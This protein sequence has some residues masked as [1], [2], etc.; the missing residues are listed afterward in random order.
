MGATRQFRIKIMI[1]LSAYKITWVEIK[2]TT[3]I[4]TKADNAKIGGCRDLDDKAKI[5][6]HFPTREAALSFLKS[7]DKKL[8]KRYEC[9]LFS[10][11]QF[12]MRNKS[13]NYRVPFTAKQL[14]E[15]YYI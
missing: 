6:K 1:T 13:D 12:A 3:G 5:Y 11:K 2:A 4:T 8:N 7:F 9:R 14:N 15:V 10:D